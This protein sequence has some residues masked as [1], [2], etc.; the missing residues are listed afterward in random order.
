MLC[1]RERKEMMEQAAK[2]R[3]ILECT[4]QEVNRNPPEYIEGTTATTC[5]RRVTREAYER[6]M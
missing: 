4:S 1:W 3:K 6:L 5:H 2:S